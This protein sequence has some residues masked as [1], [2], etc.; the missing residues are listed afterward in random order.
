VNQGVQDRRRGVLS[1]G[2]NASAGNLLAELTGA[3]E[4]F[5]VRNDRRTD[6]LQGAVDDLNKSIAA[7]QVG[8]GGGS[9]SRVDH[10]AFAKFLQTG[11]PQANMRESS[12]PDGGWT[13]PEKI[14]DTIQ[15]QLLE[16]SPLR[17]W[18]SIVTLGRGAGTYSF[19]V[20][21]RGASSGWVGE[22]DA[23]PQTDTPSLG[24]IMPAEGEIY[25]NARI[26]QWLLND[27]KFNLDAFIR[28]N[29]LDEFAVQEGTAFVSGDG[30]NKPRGF[31][32]HDT[33]ATDDDTRPFGTMQYVPTGVAAD[34]NDV[35]N[36]GVDALI[37][38]V[39]AVRP[40]YRAGPG[41][42]WMMNST[43]AS[44]VR[45][46]KDNDDRYLWQES[47]Q[48]G[49]PPMLLGYP[50]AMEENM[51][52][53]SANAFPIAFG[54]WR[55]GYRIVDRLGTRILRDPY[56]DKPFVHFYLTKRVGG[57]MADSNSI[58]LLKVAT[59]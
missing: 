36:N 2:A 45:K 8:A 57:G 54:N 41:V 24:K 28:E 26:T 48:A 53:V 39:Y 33:A 34:L 46:L 47:T 7:L 21:R 44:K 10:S 13:V 38:L 14:D 50:V 29:I 30:V 12:D 35:S 31:L 4:D 18:A 23:R 55:R 51:P 42:G 1:V 5:K 59:S 22:T 37:N 25:A 11:M 17:R 43:T 20:N 56:T 27:S 49:Q 19:L 15:Y 9:P 6:Q 52:T 40:S 3:F 32:T 16:F 58:K